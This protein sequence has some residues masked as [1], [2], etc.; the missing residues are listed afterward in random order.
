MH[1]ILQFLSSLT[2][3]V[4]ASMLSLIIIGIL[5]GLMTMMGQG[6]TMVVAMM[7]Q[8]PISLLITLAYVNVLALMLSHYPIYTYM[9]ADINRSGDQFIWKRFSMFGPIFSW[10]PLYNF[11][12]NPHPSSD[13]QYKPDRRVHYFRYALG[14]LVYVVWAQILI[15]SYSANLRFNEQNLSYIFWTTHL[16]S[17]IPI[18]VYRHFHKKIST[19]EDGP[20]KG[21]ML[22]NLALV[23]L[24]FA[25][26]GFTLIAML[27]LFDRFSL[28]GLYLL[29]ILNFVML[30]N[31]VFFR[32]LRAH[33][34]TTLKYV[35][36]HE[37]KLAHLCLRTIQ[38][39]SLSENYLRLFMA[40]FILSL[41]FVI[42]CIIESLNGGALVN[43]LP[44][45]MAYLYCYS[46]LIATLAKFFLVCRLN[47]SSQVRSE[48]ANSV[49]FKVA[50]W[51]I[52]VLALMFAI[53]FITPVHTHELDQIDAVDTLTDD[54]FSDALMQRGDTLF[55]IASHGGGLK[56]SVWTL[57]VMHTLDTITD[58]EML[59]QS[60]A[61]SGASGGSLGLALYTALSGECSEAEHDEIVKRIDQMSAKNHTSLDLT[62]L[63]G[64][65]F[66]R[67]LFPFNMI[68]GNH[69]RAYH[70]MLRYQNYVEGHD[71]VKNNELSKEGFRS[72]W[73]KVY[74]S[75]NR[76][77]PSLIMNT[78]ASNG[79]RGIIWSLQSER[80]NDVFP[81]SQNLGDLQG[82]AKTLSFYQGV[83][84][85]DRFPIF[86]P[87]AKVS[88]YGH[89][90]DAGAIDNSGLLGCFDYYNM[91]KSH[92]Q[93]RD[94]MEKKTI[95]FVEIVNS[96]SIYVQQLI[97]EF[98]YKNQAIIKIKENETPTI[99]T[100]IQTGTNLDKI[101]GYMSDLLKLQSQ[102]K[103]DFHYVR[104][105]LPHRVSLEDAEHFLSG[106]VKNSS[107]RDVRCELTNF[108]NLHNDSINKRIKNN[109]GF[110]TSWKCLEPELSRHF[111]TSNINYVK[112]ILQH[113][114]VLK[115]I[116]R[117]K[118]LASAPKRK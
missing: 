62:M 33:F 24:G 9:A 21:K 31:F 82:G 6:L 41:L 42:Y 11:E 96:K 1:T 111:S 39:L 59:R 37:N 84:M 36:E 43:G 70:A 68:G 58:G 50:F 63:M 55:F 18:L 57:N 56:A 22:K 30:F 25:L 16:S 53:R 78:S 86:S 44:I 74:L 40:C 100:D 85:T 90:I 2:K 23:Y 26:A 105:L 52:G 112:A 110:F 12:E 46:Y 27:L 92:S 88:G 51:G 73:E 64:P 93:H 95:V 49:A 60:A 77:F 83:S 48:G 32:L 118:E 10:I 14:F 104:I 71:G 98:E 7:E 89:Y 15:N 79:L 66:Y 17:I 69:D 108:L 34:R 4:K 94:E 101:P 72:F 91:L 20:K 67:K 114:R 109:T 54:Q 3:F 87:A 38:P 13:T 47:S 99:V 97:K 65:D 61:M 75:R 28:F 116:K 80:F 103:S 8:E 45:L 117:I 113:P 102:K 107:R 19:M 115:Q 35:N 76:L 29:L 106:K 81:H 5:F